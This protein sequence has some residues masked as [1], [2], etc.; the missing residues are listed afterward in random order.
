MI[1]NIEALRA[2]LKA[3]VYQGGEMIL[4][5]FGGTFRIDEKEGINNLVTEVD[6][7]IERTVTDMILADFPDH[8]ILGE[9]YRSERPQGVEYLWILDPIDGTVNFAHGIPLCCI[10]LALLHRD[11]LILGAVYNPMMDEFFFAEKGTGAFLNDQPIRV[12]GKSDFAHACL[13]TGFPYSWQAADGPHPVDVFGH[14]VKQGLPIRRL[15]SAA[16]DLCWVACG[17]FDGFWEYNLSPWDIAAGY[18]LVAEAGGKVS[19]FSGM[20]ASVFHRQTLATNGRIHA[21]MQQQIQGVFNDY[22]FQK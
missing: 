2:K 19:D 7:A 15:G 18:L 8:G 11:E 5:R 12:S 17:R 16:L 21:E 3:C 6:Q 20:P 14:F 1:A 22:S 13:V 4:S 9:E 10:S